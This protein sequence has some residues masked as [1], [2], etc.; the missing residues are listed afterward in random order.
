[1]KAILIEQNAFQEMQKNIQ[2]VKLELLIM[3]KELQNE[4]DDILTVEQVK[5]KFKV[6]RATLNNWHREGILTKK[7]VGGRV[8]YKS[9]EVYNLLN[10]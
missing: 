8:Y 3:K 7:Y 1:M 6:T 9:D 4:L 10:Q 2:D 5:T